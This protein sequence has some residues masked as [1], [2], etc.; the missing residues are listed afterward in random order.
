MGDLLLPGNAP[1]V[2]A[3]GLMVLIGA[4]ESISLLVGLSLTEHAGSLLATH[5]GLD[6]A[7]TDVEPGAFGQFLGW[8]HVGRVPLLIVLILFLLGF[9]IVGLALQGLLH[10]TTGWMAP[11][12][13]AAGVAAIGALPFVRQM[14][15]L[16]CRYLPQNETTAVSEADFIGRTAQIVTGTAS[17]GTPAEARFVDEF[18]QPH[19]IRVEPDEADK[20]F[21]R[22]TAVLLV[23]RVSGT[24]YRAIENP[25]PDLLS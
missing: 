10:A 5:F 4:L 18:G 24:L 12:A 1:F 13:L 6:Q 11:P 25:R 7:H 16:I 14:G 2:V 23:S 15:G 20:T 19:Y 17:A 9:A 22:G 3:I 21:S 8:L